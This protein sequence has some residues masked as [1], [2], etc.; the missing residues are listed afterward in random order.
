MS[1]TQS[2]SV[3]YSNQKQ[4][5]LF[6]LSQNQTFI[7]EESSKISISAKQPNL[8]SESN[9]SVNSFKINDESNEE[10]SLSEIFMRDTSNA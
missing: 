10:A 7:K 8:Y 9:K 2:K 1:H 4:Q 3:L 6:L 5:S